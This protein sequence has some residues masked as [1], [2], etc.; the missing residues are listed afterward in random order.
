MYLA[1]ADKPSSSP[2]F[3]AVFC[4]VNSSSEVRRPTS[5]PVIVEQISRTATMQLK[6]T[7]MRRRRHPQPG[8]PGLRPNSRPTGEKMQKSNAV[9]IQD[10]RGEL[11][12]IEGHRMPR[13]RGQLVAGKA[14]E[15]A[16]GI[17]GARDGEMAQTG[18]A[19]PDGMHR[20]LPDR[21]A[22]GC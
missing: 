6:S 7:A 17:A 21:R 13:R 12:L 20:H 10:V 5:S 1:S 4:A 15:T 3:Q 22:L 14:A 8:W 18:G 11:C 2:R 19:I 9:A 16:A